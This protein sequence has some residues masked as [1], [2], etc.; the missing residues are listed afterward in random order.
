[1]DT[2]TNNMDKDVN[3]LEKNNRFPSPDREQ[4]DSLSKKAGDK[5]EGFGD[6]LREHGAEK[7][8]KMVHDIGDK[9]EHMHDDKNRV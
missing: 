2:N 3:G 5:I 4:S 1:M 9:I 7:A 8:G 6:K